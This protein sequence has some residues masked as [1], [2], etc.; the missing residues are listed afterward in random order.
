M[1][2]LLTAVCA[3]VMTCAVLMQDS[4]S[5]ASATTPLLGNTSVPR[6]PRAGI[7]GSSACPSGAFTIGARIWVDTF[8]RVTGFA[9]ICTSSTGTPTV[10][11]LVGDTSD[12]VAVGDSRCAGTDLAVGLRAANGEVINA[13][14]VRCQGVGGTYNAAVIGNQTTIKSNADCDSGTAITGILGWYNIYGGPHINVYGVQG[15]CAPIDTTP[16]VTTVAA[17]RSPDSNGWYNHPF[18]ATWST[19]EPNATCT[20]TT[21]SGPDT[22]AGS[23]TGT[24]TDAAGNVSQP[25]AFQ[26][27][28]DATAPTVTTPPFTYVSVNGQGFRISAHDN[29]SGVA[30]VQATLRPALG[31]G[32]TLVRNATCISGCGTTDS[33]WWVSTA[34]TVGVYRVTARATDFAGNTSAP[35]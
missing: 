11:D 10:G 6:I 21:Y 5:A 34:G 30:S 9:A 22:A 17:D 14:G 24:C 31:L 15:T 26:F 35:Q 23:L 12:A 7:P 33:Q 2:R 4:A 19:P 20:S 3:A 8:P 29:L 16:P 32:A 25:V 27:K 13:M 18:T 28:Y 1:K